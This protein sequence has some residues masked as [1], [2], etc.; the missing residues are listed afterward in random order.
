[1]RLSI[2]LVAVLSVTP[3]TKAQAQRTQPCTEWSQWLRLPDKPDVSFS[4][5][6]CELTAQRLQ[7]IWKWSNESDEEFDFTY[8]I[9][10]RSPIGC[11]D[12]ARGALAS[13]DHRLAAQ[14][15]EGFESGRA[16]ARWSRYEGIFVCVSY[17]GQPAPEPEPPSLAVGVRAKLFLATAPPGNYV[18]GTVT[19]IET[20]RVRL[21]V[22]RAGSLVADTSLSV[23]LNLVNQIAISRGRSNRAD[24][25]FVLGAVAGLATGAAL[26]AITADYRCQEG[27]FF[28]NGFRFEERCTGQPP[29][30]RAVIFGAVSSVIGGAAGLGIGFILRVERWA[31]V[32]VSLVPRPEGAFTLSGGMKF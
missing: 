10:V 24:V 30:E 18:V 2:L 22:E 11:G 12:K 21:A 25:G 13:A 5:R 23:P 4:F 17:E 32:D 20:D 3:L 27:I 29:L 9:H 16:L 31:W 8:W 6:L 28:E 7:V 19:A 1:M 26:G 14:T 15:T